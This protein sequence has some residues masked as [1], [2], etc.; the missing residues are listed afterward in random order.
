MV[1]GTAPAPIYA[2]DPPMYDGRRPAPP[3]MTADHAALAALNAPASIASRRAAIARQDRLASGPPAEPDRTTGAAGTGESM[4][5]FMKRAQEAL[6]IEATRWTPQEGEVMSGRLIRVR[7]IDGQY[8]K[9]FRVLTL[10][11]PSGGTAV[12]VSEKTSL[13]EGFDEVEKLGIGCN[14]AV[15]Y[16]GN[17]VGKS[18]G[19]YEAYTCYS[20]RG[21]AQAQAQPAPATNSQQAA[22]PATQP[23][24]AAGSAPAANPAPEQATDA[25]TMTGL[26]KAAL[27]NSDQNDLTRIGARARDLGLVWDRAAQR[28]NAPAAAADA[29]L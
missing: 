16:L 24:P 12:D 18:G 19:R 10:V 7:Q 8:D 9:P 26:A 28:Y 15:K 3:V 5:D 11:P 1:P 2:D 29:V 4:S 13:K 25:A 17:R 14:V 21:E 20:E 6:S 27:A 22:A 23:A